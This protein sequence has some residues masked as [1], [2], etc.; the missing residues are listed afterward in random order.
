M[1]VLRIE[2]PV[3]DFDAWDKAFHSDPIGR[4]KSG[5]RSYR[6]LRATDNLNYVMIDLEFESLDKAKAAH[7]ALLD[8]WSHVDVIK[9]PQ[10]RTAEIVETKQY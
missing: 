6:V 3:G 1:Y 9:N 8:L 5:V 2:H 7:T 4:E 10:A